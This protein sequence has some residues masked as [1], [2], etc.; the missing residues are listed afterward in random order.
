SGKPCPRLI[1]PVS[2]ARALISAKI[3]AAIEPSGLRSPAP[4]AVRCQPPCSSIR[5]PSDPASPPE[6]PR[7]VASPTDLWIT[8][9]Q[10]HRTVLLCRHECSV[11]ASP[12]DAAAQHRGRRH[13]PAGRIPRGLH[14]A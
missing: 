10:R 1:A 2:T 6:G 3:V 13:V 8:L 5:A 11:G 4:A 9:P 12:T 7:L 14:S